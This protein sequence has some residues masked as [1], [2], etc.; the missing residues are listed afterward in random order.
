MQGNLNMGGFAIRNIKPF[1]E[2]DSSQ[3]ASD[4]QKNDV[5]NYGYF[6]DQRDDLKLLIN[7]TEICSSSKRWF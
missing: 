2:N 7:T 5:I 6:K 4:A 1:V 3:A